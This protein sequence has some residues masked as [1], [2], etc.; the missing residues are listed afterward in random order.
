MDLQVAPK[1][2]SHAQ[3]LSLRRQDLAFFGPRSALKMAVSADTAGTAGRQDPEDQQDHADLDLCHEA[4]KGIEGFR[5]QVLSSLVS[6]SKGAA[7]MLGPSFLRLADDLLNHPLHQT[8]TSLKLPPTTHP[9]GTRSP[10]RNKGALIIGIGLGGMDYIRG[11]KGYDYTLLCQTSSCS[12]H[13]SCKNYTG[14]MKERYD[15]QIFRRL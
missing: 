4:L 3:L 1:A 12:T 11:L 8:V 7:L 13:T 6:E 9:G 2:S 10:K 14:T 15:Y 5:V